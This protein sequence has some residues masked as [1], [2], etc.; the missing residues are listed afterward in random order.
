VHLTHTVVAMMPLVL[1]L[2]AATLVPVMQDTT[3]MD[4]PAQVCMLAT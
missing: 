3:V 4:L 2:W 1:I